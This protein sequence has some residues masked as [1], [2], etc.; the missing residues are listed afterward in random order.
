VFS[1]SVEKQ[2]K[3]E[4]PQRV[5]VRRGTEEYRHLSGVCPNCDGEVKPKRQEDLKHLGG[6]EEYL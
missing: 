5:G 6:G 4:R 2:V 3:G 1:S